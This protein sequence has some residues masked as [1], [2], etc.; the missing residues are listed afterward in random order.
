MSSNPSFDAC[1]ACAG[2]LTSAFD[3][4]YDKIGVTCESIPSTPG[5]GA[6]S[7]LAQA[8]TPCISAVQAPMQKAG[9]VTIY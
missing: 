2:A 6:Q 9:Y 4:V 8:M 5:G 7:N 3:P 1:D